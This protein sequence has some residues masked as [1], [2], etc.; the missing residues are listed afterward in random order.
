[1]VG[2]SNH[3]LYEVLIPK[4]DFGIDTVKWNLNVFEKYEYLNICVVGTS[5][6][7]LYEVLIPKQDFRKNKV[8]TGKTP[9]F[10]IGPF[11]NSHA[12]QF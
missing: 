6:H 8:V 2:T 5:N 12:M 10:V 1:M 7:L 11:C 3:L 4:Q 9:F